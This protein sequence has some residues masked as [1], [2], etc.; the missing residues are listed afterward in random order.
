MVQQGMTSTL[1]NE[2]VATK[3]PKTDEKKVICFFIL[4]NKI[5]VSPS[6]GNADFGLQIFTEL[7]LDLELSC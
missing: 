6:E 5:K 7:A 1:P 2:T 4:H 3:H